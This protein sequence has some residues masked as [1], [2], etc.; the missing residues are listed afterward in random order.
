[1]KEIFTGSNVVLKVNG[2]TLLPGGGDYTLRITSRC[3]CPSYPWH[4]DL[5][6]DT[7]RK[8]FDLVHKLIHVKAR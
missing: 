5:G 3:T 6:P 7:R 1:M 4:D 8:L 2:V